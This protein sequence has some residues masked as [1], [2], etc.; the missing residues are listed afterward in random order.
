MLQKLIDTNP[1]HAWMREKFK[2][3]LEM[4]SGKTIRISFDMNCYDY[5]FDAEKVIDQFGDGILADIEEDYGEYLSIAST[6]ANVLNR[7]M[8]SIAAD[9]STH[10]QASGMILES[11]L[12]EDY[13]QALV[14]VELL[15]NSLKLYNPRAIEIWGAWIMELMKYVESL[16][17]PGSTEV[18]WESLE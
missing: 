7:K 9:V 3:E 12:A 4:A 15:C 13:D 11:L 18:D 14:G 17:L 5:Y 2:F 10:Y 6:I 16:D 1:A 8:E